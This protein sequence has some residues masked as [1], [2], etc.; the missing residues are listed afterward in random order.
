MDNQAYLN[1]I[2]TGTPPSFNTDSTSQIQTLLPKIFIGL[3]AFLV[4][5]VIGVLIY[6]AAA[7]AN[8]QATLASELKRIY[9][10]S[11]SLNSLITTYSPK[12]STSNL[13][14]TS[15]SLSNVLSTISTTASYTLTNSYGITLDSKTTPSASDQALINSS[16]KKLKNRLNNGLSV[17]ITYATELS[18]QL[19][20]LISLLDSALTKVPETDRLHTSLTSSRSSLDTLR[21]VFA[22]YTNSAT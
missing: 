13:R 17:D 20:L 22:S 9:L 5:S 8:P 19:T 10:R 2:S 11:N 21:K 3:L 16:I 1:S 7:P 15:N 18:S 14:S 6:S 12:V 4:I